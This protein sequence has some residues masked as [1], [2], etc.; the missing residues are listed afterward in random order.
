MMA[1]GPLIIIGVIGAVIAMSSHRH[2]TGT[3]GTTGTTGL[4]APVGSG[5]PTARRIPAAAEAL[6]YLGGILA[7]VGLTLAIAQWW[8]EMLTVT[9]LLVTATAAVALIVAGLFVPE[10]ND[11]ALARLRWFLWLLATAAA[12]AFGAVL[13][14]DAFDSDR[15]DRV[16]LTIAGFVLAVGGALWAWRER[17]LQQF[18]TLVAFTVTTGTL[19]G[20]VTTRP[21][22]GVAVW[23]V[24]V[25][26]VVA[27]LRA[28]TPLPLITVVV[29][30]ATAVV[31]AVI[32]MP[33]EIGP[34]LLFVVATAIAV[35]TLAVSPRIDDLVMQRLLGAVG[36]LT[37]LQS[38][39]ATLGH[40]ATDAGIVTGL[41]V[42]AAGVALLVVGRRDVVRVPLLVMIA[43]GVLVL[44]GAALTGVQ[45]VAFAT[46]FGLVTAVALVA[47]G[48]LPGHVLLSVFGSLGLL[49]NVPWAIAHFFPG[50]GRVPLLI[51]VSG[52]LIIA[53]AVLLARSGKRLRAELGR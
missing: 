3:T 35:M 25:G 24:G 6:G 51:T 40:F 44:G 20:M 8:D 29:G 10:Q 43:G 26:F 17:P 30:A 48:M 2:A 1:L 4:I 13:A 34:G 15:S 42:W 53:V 27:G 9:R 32:T 39:P 22:A 18:T 41:V 33:D 5:G 12:G 52:V 19:V 36:V 38:V 21:A 28:L 50:E 23:V 14:V 11:P 31:G 37:L 7:A 47:L 46:V 45:S 16:A 49:V